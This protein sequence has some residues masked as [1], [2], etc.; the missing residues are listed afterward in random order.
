M[1]IPF[2]GTSRIPT[3][4]L[5]SPST[6]SEAEA[7]NHRSLE[8]VEGKSDDKGII[9]VGEINSITAKTSVANFRNDNH[10]HPLASTASEDEKSSLPAYELLWICGST[11]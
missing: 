4:K 9:A 8:V 11:V 6:S 2:F 1:R 3:T 7:G 5:E 10:V